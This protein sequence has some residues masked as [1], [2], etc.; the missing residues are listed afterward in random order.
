MSIL[1]RTAPF[2]FAF[3]LQAQPY[4]NLD[5][6]TAS[7]GQLWYWSYG[8]TGYQFSI[9]TTIFES[10]K[11][12]LKIQNLSAPATSFGS[13]VQ[14]IPLDLIRGKHVRIGYW[15]KTDRVSGTG[16]NPY[17][18]IYWRVADAAGKNLA[19]MGGPSTG[20]TGTRDWTFY[21]FDSDVSSSAATVNLGFILSGAGTAWFD[22]IQ[23]Q[24]DGQP[25][26][27]GSA[28]NTGEPSQDM[29]DWI[30]ANAIPITSADPNQGYDDLMPLKNIIGDAH[31][32]GLGEAT[33][34]TAEFF[35]MK[36]RI[37]DFLANEMGFTTFAIEANMPESYKMNDYVLNGI[38]DPEQILKGMYFWTWNTQEVLDMV[39][40]MR[41]FNQSGK[42]R[43]QFTGFDM[44]YSQVAAPIVQSFINNAEPSYAGQVSNI[45]GQLAQA[46]ANTVQGFG[47]A[48]GSFPVSAAA[49]KKLKY[50]GYIKTQGVTIG[51]AGLWWRCDGASGTLAFDNM[52]GRGA[53]G[54]N[55]WQQFEI[56]MT[57][58]ANT[59]NIL[60]GVIHPG[61]GSAWFDTLAVQLD[62]V[63]YVN[64]ALFDFDFESPTLV[65]FGVGGNA[66]SVQLDPTVAHTGRQSLRSVYQG[67]STLSNTELAQQCDAIAF[68]L[69]N[70][71]DVYL[72]EGLDVA[73][74][75][76]AIQNA[77][78]VAQ[79]AD[80]MNNGSVRDPDM[81]ANV[82]WILNQQPPGSKIVLWAHDFHVSRYGGAMGSYLDAMYGKDYVVLGFGFD[83]GS[84]SALG[85]QG[86]GP[87]NANP[88]FP[89]SAEYVFLKTG[90]Q[91]FVLDLRKATPENPASSWLLNDIMFRTIGAVPVDGFSVTHLAHDYD[92]LIFFQHSSPST[93]LH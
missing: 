53:T 78:I 39:N 29:V 54:T 13:G 26:V 47:V 38:G 7:R 10:G 81:A 91:Q 14:T 25:L 71:L 46:S 11:Q 50:T 90:I 19:F 87:Y 40:W 31:I 12:S 36:H 33:H 21:Q 44:Q 68:H 1:L 23:L 57:I 5:F 22:N 73:D 89:G 80:M 20:A 67:G 30:T 64:P 34:G 3:V 76:W 60:F 4:L 48:T 35:N 8:A 41:E 79:A 16:T 66:F 65:G 49:G 45:Y 42:G 82:R 93:L 27:E 92:G 24:I 75:Q 77:R 37:V 15:V 55:D 63:N 18:T 70:S 56:D 51:Y 58:P 62:G 61:N 74:I 2:L 69:E 28:P 72:E 86:L 84:Y 32:V 59:T 9:D 43:I 6:E 85:P 17:A 83:N 52:S 88:S